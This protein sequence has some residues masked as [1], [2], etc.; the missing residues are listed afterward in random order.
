MLYPCSF[1]EGLK[2]LMD[3]KHGAYYYILESVLTFSEY[4]CK[5]TAPWISNYPN[6]L[7]MAM[8]KGSPYYDIFK[9]NLL[10]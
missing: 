2:N 6:F 10:R 4:E 7:G 1:Q 8:R 5:V 3:I 9:Y